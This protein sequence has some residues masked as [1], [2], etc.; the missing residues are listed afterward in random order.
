MCITWTRILLAMSKLKILQRRK[1]FTWVPYSPALFDV[2]WRFDH[3]PIRKRLI[4]NEFTC[5]FWTHS[6]YWG[7]QRPSVFGH[8]VIVLSHSYNHHHYYLH[9]HHYWHY[10]IFVTTRC[11]SPHKDL[12]N[13]HSQNETRSTVAPHKVE[14]LEAPLTM[15]LQYIIHFILLNIISH[16]FEYS[17][18]KSLQN[19]NSLKMLKTHL[20]V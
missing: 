4:F 9:C 19:R 3:T 2:H 6:W 13:E 10:L 11:G 16:H 18:L 12:A 8:S 7:D 20:K 15:T 1:V 17:I 5:Q 14:S